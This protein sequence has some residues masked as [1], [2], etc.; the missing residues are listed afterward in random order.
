MNWY[1]KS[2]LSNLPGGFVFPSDKDESY[3]SGDD[4][5]ANIKYKKDLQRRDDDIGFQD[6]KKRNERWRKVYPHMDKIKELE[7]QL[8]N[9]NISDM[10]RKDIR[11]RI[12]FSTAAISHIL[13]TV[14]EV[15]DSTIAPGTTH[16]NFNDYKLD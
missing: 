5:Y 9:P 15:S 2:Q 14:G 12:G 6:S 3:F 16:Y 7:E 1:K 13:N 8:K 11:K 10:E 4:D